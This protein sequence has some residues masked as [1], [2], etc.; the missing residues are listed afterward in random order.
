MTAQ[1]AA[2]SLESNVIGTFNVLAACRRAGCRLVYVSTNAV[3]DGAAAP[4]REDDSVAPINKYGHLKV[5]CERL[6][7]ET[8][9]DAVIV[10]PILMYG[11]NHPTGR[12]NPATWLIDRLGRRD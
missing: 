6:V 1:D 10:R 8:L 11:W 9:G 2:E 5:E 4:Y 12:S 7:R 3:F